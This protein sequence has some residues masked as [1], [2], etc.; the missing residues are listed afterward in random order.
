MEKRLFNS[1]LHSFTTDS[2]IVSHSTVSQEILI[3]FLSLSNDPEE[4]V[5]N[6]GEVF[7]TCSNNIVSF[8]M[9]KNNF[10][11]L[12]FTQKTALKDIIDCQLML[13]KNF[14][15]IK[16]EKTLLI[17]YFVGTAMLDEYFTEE[18][19]NQFGDTDSNNNVLNQIE[20]IQS[21]EN[22]N[23]EELLH[24][25]TQEDDDVDDIMAQLDNAVDDV[26]EQ[27]G[28]FK[29]L[30]QKSNTVNKQKFNLEQYLLSEEDYHQHSWNKLVKF[31]LNQSFDKRFQNLGA[32]TEL[33]N[34]GFYPI[35]QFNFLG[36]GK[37]SFNPYFGF[38]TFCVNK[39]VSLIQIKTGKLIFT[40]IFED[41]VEILDIVGVKFFGSNLVK[42]EEKPCLFV[43]DAS[44][45]LTM[46]DISNFKKSC[47][48]KKSKSKPISLIYKSGYL[49]Y[50]LDKS[51]NFF[52]FEKTNNTWE[53]VKNVESESTFDS[54][55]L[56]YLYSQLF[57]STV[58]GDKF[59]LHNIP[60]FL[61]QFET[62]LPCTGE[63]IFFSLKNGVFLK[64]N[65]EI[66]V[67]GLDIAYKPIPVS[68]SKS[69]YITTQVPQYIES[70]DSATSSPPVAKLNLA[71]KKKA[72]DASESHN[73]SNLVNQN[74]QKLEERGERLQDLGKKTGDL[75][76]NA[77]KFTDTIKAYNENQKNKK[78]WQL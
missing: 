42:F 52:K 46:L 40:E 12:L 50:L 72:T 49:F 66:K 44:G 55:S 30:I 73:T 71:K 69:T 16:N 11:S 23:S 20:L 45:C 1:K 6:E 17:Y 22:L 53:L 75:S 14:F 47:V 19:L 5:K 24:Q 60:E 15:W 63:E 9:Y 51:I 7:M 10:S 18:K 29:N 43:A 64:R 32:T 31:D 3:D 8:W 70:T 13:D 62:S 36:K 76:A 26:L 35:F 54:G 21:N 78:W 77:R 48:L 25:I 68:E 56:I 41:G 28:A 37:V 61:V 38:V 34:I 39:T 2:N 58:S 74:K 65:G 4:N 67:F 27:T 33:K 59:K 57:F